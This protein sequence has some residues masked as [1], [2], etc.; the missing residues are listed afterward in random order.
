M[1]VLQEQLKYCPHCDRQTVHQRNTKRM[2][3]GMHIFLAIITIGTWLFFW[4]IAAV[5][6]LL[7]KPIA[8]RWVCSTCGQKESHLPTLGRLLPPSPAPALAIAL[9]APVPAVVA[10]INAPKPAA[11]PTKPKPQ[12][13]PPA[14][15]SRL[16]PAPMPTTQHAPPTSPCHCGR[17][18]V[19]GYRD[20][21]HCSA[22]Y[23]VNA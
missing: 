8:A 11:A 17:L 23:A 15:P 7:T 2:S 10:P 13:K 22:P 20:C 1:L 21:P 4:L 12:T 3:W 6:H 16:A 14:I 9:A 5:W 18:Q 19:P